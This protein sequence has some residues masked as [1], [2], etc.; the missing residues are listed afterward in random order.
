MNAS[1]HWQSIEK[2]AHHGI[3][4]P[5]FSLRTKKSC[6]IGEFLDLIALI[7]GCKALRFDCIQLLP[8]NDTGEDPSP[9]NPLS[10]CALNPIYLSLKELPD[11]QELAAD[12]ALFEPL[13]QMPR[14]AYGQVKHQKLKWLFSYFLK[15]FSS[16]S[17]LPS[18]Q[19]FIQQ[20]KSWLTPYTAFKALKDEYGNK[21]WTDWPTTYRHFDPSWTTEFQTA[22]DFHT[23]LQFHCFQQMHQVRIHAEQKKVF[24]IGDMP[25]L[26]SPDSADVWAHPELFQ[27][28]LAAG[29]PPDA[30]NAQGQKWGFPLFQWQAHRKTHFAWWK[31]RLHALESFYHLYRIDHVVGFFRIWAIPKGKPATE[32]HFVPA[33]PALWL[34]QGKE[35]LSMMLTHCS[36]LP[37]AEDLG[38]IPKELYPLLK[39]LQICGTKVLRWQ[40]RWETDKSYLPYAEYEPF[41]L[42]SVST[43]DSSTLSGWWQEDTEEAMAFARFKHWD[44]TPELSF[45]ERLELL[46]DAHHTPSYFHINL[47]QEYLALFPELIEGSA[48]AERINVPGTFLP[49][50]WTYRYV[51]YLEE[52]FQH[53]PFQNAIHSI[54]KENP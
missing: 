15:H 10:S 32:G 5:L 25:I 35:L 45:E 31:E 30:Y 39:E 44:Y 50:N 41:S 26:L 36:L 8:L 43:A 3:C 48:S 11:P 38:T 20:N 22:I 53:G 16:H 14:V 17:Q 12:L 4:V 19:Q 47:L 37:L 42:T 18:Y 24:L 29:A 6:G 51:P 1:K 34:S 9:Y 49:T 40:R 2:K 23:F 13:T 46:R 21:Q 28:D 33:D 54:L 27:M 7:D 52:L